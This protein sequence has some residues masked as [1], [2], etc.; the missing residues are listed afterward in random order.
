M[1]HNRSSYKAFVWLLTVG[2]ISFYSGSLVAE[3]MS[4]EQKLNQQL[5]KLEIANRQIVD[6]AAELN[7]AVGRPG[8][9]W[10]SHGFELN[11]IKQRIN[12]IGKMIPELQSHTAIP[13]WQKDLIDQI[14]AFVKVMSEH[15]EKAIKFV[16][17]HQ[18]AE[19]L[20]LR[21]GYVLRVEGIY[22][23][24]RHVDN[25]VEYADTRMTMKDLE[26]RITVS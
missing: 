26:E 2:L 5:R 8:M 22:Q 7:R 13:D 25:L 24:A 15:T 21:K 4:D 3:D 11:L 9:S 23:V 10:Q 6:H 12:D 19:E 18:H 17:E 20:V 16:S 1:M 14:S